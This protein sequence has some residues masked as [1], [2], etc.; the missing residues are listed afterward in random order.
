MIVRT[1][2]GAH[3]LMGKSQIRT[4]TGRKYPN[5]TYG[6][7]RGRR[8]VTD[9]CSVI[10]GMILIKQTFVYKKGV[11]RK[12]KNIGKWVFTTVLFVI[13]LLNLFKVQ[14]VKADG[15]EEVS[16]EAESTEEITEVE[17]E[18]I[19]EDCQEVSEK[20]DEVDNIEPNYI[21]DDVVD[22]EEDLANTGYYTV[23]F[24]CGSGNEIELISVND[25]KYL[26][27]LTLNVPKGERIGTVMQN[28]LISKNLSDYWTLFRCISQ[29]EHKWFDGWSDGT[30]FYEDLWGTDI[31]N[32]SDIIPTKDLVFTPVYSQACIITFDAGKDSKGFPVYADG[33]KYNPL[34]VTE[35][36]Y[37]DS[38]FYKGIVSYEKQRK[39]KV[40]KGFSLW[41]IFFDN[42]VDATD[43]YRC[44]LSP[45]PEDGQ[46]YCGWRVGEDKLLYNWEIKH[47]EESCYDDIYY[48]DHLITVYQAQKDV[49]FVAS[50]VSTRISD[51]KD[52][53]V[54]RTHIQSYG[55]SNYSIDGEVSGTV[56]EGKRLEGIDLMLTNHPYDGELE[57]RTHVQSY[58]WQDW[59]QNGAMSGTSGQAKRLE[60][61][62]IRLTGEM[63]KHYDVY[64]RVQAQTYGWLGWAKNG[65]Y[66][67]TAG[68]AKR[69]E[70]IQVVLV[71]KGKAIDKAGYDKLAGITASTKVTPEKAYITK[72][73][74]IMYRTHV[75]TFGWQGFVSNG[76]VSGTT[77]QSKRLEGI[78]IKLGN[79]PYEGGVRYKTHVQ[80]YGW[81]GWKQ[82]GAMSGTSGES[83][84]L[85]AISIEL[86]GELAKHYD[87]YYRVH[88]Q[89]YG[90]LGWAKNGQNSGTAGK[91]KRL[92][93]IQIILVEKGQPAPGKTYNGITANSKETYIT[94]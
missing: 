74:D 49:T 94:N 89:T 42:I 82:N 30:T 40:K 12:M 75:Q 72:T 76:L 23:K 39:Y 27:S 66:S 85:E 17:A 51:E 71:D 90:W 77:G 5:G 31:D 91:A 58:G 22:V 65:E 34:C 52:T 60:A 50:Y 35:D 56:G 67:G 43:Y 15:T 20:D 16:I 55:W 1:L 19:K 59:K 83:K 36:P 7:M 13:L 25:Y 24:N 53:I 45:V 18:E 41:D 3:F 80:T 93:G 4:V 2:S 63:A 47:S 79:L 64:Y 57:Y 78:E 54:Y 70:A 69:L 10:S 62:Q 44:N 87:V 92:E 68:L 6:V 84:R 11:Y 37:L 46:K 61:I 28:Y 21:I 26:D 29:D 88:A 48:D 33:Q 86:T 8:L 14:E 81:Q 38:N 32:I 73:P 9:A